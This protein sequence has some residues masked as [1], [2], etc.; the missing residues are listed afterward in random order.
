MVVSSENKYKMIYG[1]II[2]FLYFMF[3]LFQIIVSL[4]FKSAFTDAIFIPSDIMGG[5]IL[6][7]ISAVFLFGVKELNKGIDEGVAYIYVGILLAILFMIIYSLI[8]VANAVSAYALSNPDL[9]NWTPLD[10]MKPGLY[11]GI[12]SIIGILIW[13]TKF[14]L[15][16]TKKIIR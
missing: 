15:S 8:I 16:R 7:V 10:N 12:L 1:I 5:I 13:R 6:I 14:V 9:K 3:G 2:G 11:L 4:G